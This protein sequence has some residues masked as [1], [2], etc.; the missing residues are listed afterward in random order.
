M[1]QSPSDSLALPRD[2]EHLPTPAQL[3][4]PVQQFT[5]L[6]RYLSAPSFPPLPTL[7]LTVSH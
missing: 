1:T 7:G 2:A 3:P 5:T 6:T 4:G